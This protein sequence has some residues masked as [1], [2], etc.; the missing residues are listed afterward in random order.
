MTG[1][2]TYDDSPPGAWRDALAP[3]GASCAACG[4][5]V[6]DH[7]D[8]EYAGVVPPVHAAENGRG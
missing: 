5:N 6:C 2:L 8:L 3:E 1:T 7:S 4:Q